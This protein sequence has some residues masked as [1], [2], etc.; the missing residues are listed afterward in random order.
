[1]GE[2]NLDGVVQMLED[3]GET[4]C[5]LDVSK[6]KDPASSF[7][8][9]AGEQIDDLD[10]VVS[11]AKLASG[12]LPGGLPS[13]EACLA[14]LETQCGIFWLVEYTKCITSSLLVF[15]KNSIGFHQNQIHHNQSM[16]VSIRA[17]K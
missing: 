17:S 15:G 4:I 6:V 3:T 10:N 1:M 5:K 7:S 2:V 12:G 14:N 11:A 16:I 8:E 9:Q 13:L